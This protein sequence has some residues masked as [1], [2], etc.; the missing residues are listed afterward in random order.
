MW[1]VFTGGQMPYDSMRNADVV[2]FVC[3]LNKRL[4]KPTA[5]TQRLYNIMLECWNK[6]TSSSLCLA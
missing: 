4:P 3:N 5:S 1:E 6:V 2:D